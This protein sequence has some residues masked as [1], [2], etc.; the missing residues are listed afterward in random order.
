M[1]PLNVLGLHG[2]PRG[3]CGWQRKGESPTLKNRAGQWSAKETQ[4]TGC[5]ETGRNR[6]ERVALEARE[7][8]F[9]QERMM[10]VNTSDASAK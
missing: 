4:R 5:S 1:R 10:K 3:G 7:R 8:S 2:V 9:Q 6:G